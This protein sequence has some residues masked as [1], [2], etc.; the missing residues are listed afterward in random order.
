MSSEGILPLRNIHW[1]MAYAAAEWDDSTVAAASSD[2]TDSPIDSVARAFVARVGALVR[3]GL[4]RGYVD[5]TGELSAV[6]GRIDHLRN[7]RTQS[8]RRGRVWCSFDE[9]THDIRVNQLLRSAV[10]LVDATASLPSDVRERARAVDRV[11]EGIAVVDNVSRHR[12]P[13]HTGIFRQ[14]YQ[15]V[16][17]MARYLLCALRPVG[18]GGRDLFLAVDAAVGEPKVFERFVR[19]FLRR[20]LT[21]ATVRRVRG[22]WHD[23]IPRNSGTVG[24]LPH[25]ETDVVVEMET[26]VI[27]IETKCYRDVLREYRGTRRVRESHLYQLMAYLNNVRD[28]IAAGRQVEGVLLYPEGAEPLDACWEIQGYP[29]R[30]CTIDLAQQWS[31]VATRLIEIGEQGGLAKVPL[32]RRVY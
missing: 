20:R 3:Q 21:S 24:L 22:P 7:A 18:A 25:L 32:E 11:L 15:S 29:V 13:T 12:W 14:Q 26:R 4:A 5:C 9:L 31:E 23:A 27:V 8:L 19:G 6:R 17:A 28:T 10:R 2:R 16:L 30:V 1:I